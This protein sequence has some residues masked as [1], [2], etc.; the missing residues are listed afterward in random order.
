M[1]TLHRIQTDGSIHEV[2]RSDDGTI[3]SAD[4]LRAFVAIA[5]TGHTHGSVSHR[6]GRAPGTRIWFKAPAAH[7]EADNPTAAALADG[8]TVL[9]GPCIYEQGID[10]DDDGL[11]TI[12]EGEAEQIVRYLTALGNEISRKIASGETPY[13]PDRHNDWLDIQ[14]LIKSIKK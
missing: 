1:S 10:A 6:P 11:V 3:D 2:V 13:D 4:R 7:H 5:L 9:F 12:T 14:E 8:V